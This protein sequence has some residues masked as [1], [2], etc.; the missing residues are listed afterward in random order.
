MLIRV[1]H[2]SILE[3]RM[4]RGPVNA[5]SPELIE[6]LIPQAVGLGVAPDR[7][8]LALTPAVAGV[9]RY[10]YSIQLQL[11]PDRL[12]LAGE[13]ALEIARALQRPPAIVDI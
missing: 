2:G 12:R 10:S 7:L 5:L 11:D 1:E 6:R 4:D 9:H 3:L 13:L 8:V